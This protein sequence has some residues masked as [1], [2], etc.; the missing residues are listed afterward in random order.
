MYEV[1]E[2]ESWEERTW[3]SMGCP[4]DIVELSLTAPH[5]DAGAL[6]ATAVLRRGKIRPINGGRIGG[7][8]DLRW[9][10]VSL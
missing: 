7:R 8:W 2:G 4:Y 5:V 3:N 9:H 6:D 10:F 1:E